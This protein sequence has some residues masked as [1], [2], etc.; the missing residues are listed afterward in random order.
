M[1]NYGQSQGQ[2]DAANGKTAANLSNAHWK[3]REDYNAAF[4]REKEKQN[5]K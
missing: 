4:A 5:N 1:S 3:E 2:K